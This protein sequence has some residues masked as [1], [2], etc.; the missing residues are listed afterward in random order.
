MGAGSAALGGA[1]RRVSSGFGT[2]GEDGVMFSLFTGR[3][4]AW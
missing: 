1:R 3:G 2:R 4:A